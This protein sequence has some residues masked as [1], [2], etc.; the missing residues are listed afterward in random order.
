V[1][2]PIWGVSEFWNGTTWASEPIA[3]P[4]GILKPALAAVSCTASDNCM[5]VGLAGD[6]AITKILAEQWNGTAWV[7][8]PTPNPS[9]FSGNFLDGVSCPVAAPCT[10]TGSFFGGPGSETLAEAR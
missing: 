2:T 6:N 1:G 5:A 10:A 8:Q 7:I 3:S 4:G 9:S